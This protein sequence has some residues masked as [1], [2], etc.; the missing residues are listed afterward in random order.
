MEQAGIEKA[1]YVYTGQG[2]TKEVIQAS[3]KEKKKTGTLFLIL[4]TFKRFSGTFVFYIFN[5]WT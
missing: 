2:G 3:Q 1:G 4:Q 5:I